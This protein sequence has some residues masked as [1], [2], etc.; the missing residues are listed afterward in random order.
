MV[1][2]KNPNPLIRITSEAISEKNDTA[3]VNEVMSM[4]CADL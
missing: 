3:V 2:R 1:P 4:A